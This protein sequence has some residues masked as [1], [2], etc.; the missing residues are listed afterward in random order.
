MSASRLTEPAGDK[1]GVLQLTHGAGV[2]FGKQLP[3]E[4]DYEI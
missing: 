3:C 1:G 4:D 2:L